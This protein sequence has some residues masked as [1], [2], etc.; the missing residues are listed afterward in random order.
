MND[1]PKHIKNQE[2]E[3]EIIIA[4]YNLH[5]KL[6]FDE[7]Q[8]QRLIKFFDEYAPF[9]V[10]S[11]KE[12]VGSL[13]WYEHTK[14][15]VWWQSEDFQKFMEAYQHIRT[16]LDAIL[17]NPDEPQIQGE[18]WKWYA[19]A[20][21]EFGTLFVLDLIPSLDEVWIPMEDEDY[22]SISYGLELG[23]LFWWIL[24]Q[25]LPLIFRNP[26]RLRRCA[27]YYYPTPKVGQC[28]NIFWQTRSDKLFCSDRCRKRVQKFKGSISKYNNSSW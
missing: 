15:I 18:F 5:L 16:A 23:N 19:N 9:V 11:N 27:G 12:A 8:K 7:K 22:H 14:G 6:P 21:R 10:S 1:N 3:P 24:T 28:P 25:E 4:L 26:H 13:E 20:M 2:P 17:D